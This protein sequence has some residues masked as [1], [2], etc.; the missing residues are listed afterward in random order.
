MNSKLINHLIN[1]NE[2]KIS[3]LEKEL[4]ASPEGN[5]SCQKNGKYEKYYQVTENGRVYIPKSNKE[6]ASLLAKKKYLLSA[7][8][9]LQV[10]QEALRNYLKSKENYKP[11]RESFLNN[12][13]YRNLLQDAYLLEC[14]DEIKEWKCEDYR[15]NSLYPEQLK[16][17][18]KSGNM[19]RSK[20]E[21]MIDQILFAKGIPFRY[22]C[23]LRM[24]EMIYYPDFTIC[25]PWTGEIFFWE[26]F[27][28]MDNAQYAQKA[29]KKLQNYNENG[30]LINR[31][32]IATFETTEMPMNLTKIESIV[33]EYFCEIC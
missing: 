10:E 31:Q 30:L 21:M 2:V 5:L 11:K 15:K 13:I 7:L 14:S 16:F 6:L 24:G 1:Q 9:D 3:Q 19:V 17:K 22:E 23:E 27:G 4:L 28:M 12:Q 33:N 20:T 29:F 32:L 8:Q 26:H 18:C 25:H